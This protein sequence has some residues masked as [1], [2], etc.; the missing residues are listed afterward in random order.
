MDR[1]ATVAVIDP[2]HDHPTASRRPSDHLMRLALG[3]A[4]LNAL[5]VPKRFFNL[6]NRDMPLRM[7]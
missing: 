4:G 7:V 3:Q 2:D 6:M 5:A 1:I